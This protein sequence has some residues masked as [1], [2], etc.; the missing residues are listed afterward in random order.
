V[1]AKIIGLAARNRLLVLSGVAALAA[2]A[3]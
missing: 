3:V 2:G 1:I